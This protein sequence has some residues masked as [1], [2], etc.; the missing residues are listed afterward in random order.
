[1]STPE[2]YVATLADYTRNHVN[3][4]WLELHPDEPLDAQVAELRARSYC[5]DPEELII[6][7]TENFQGIDI[8]ESMPLD[9]VAKVGER[10]RTHGA[11][12]AAFVRYA[13]GGSDDPY[14]YEPVRF[15]GEYDD[16]EAW[17]EDVTDGL[18]PL[19]GATVAAWG[20]SKRVPVSGD[21]RTNL[22]DIRHALQIDGEALALIAEVN[23]GYTFAEHNGKVFV[24]SN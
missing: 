22:R 6:L 7:D 16:L 12:Y 11:P 3:A 19:L 8:H 20:R 17:A 18:L 2:I 4:A 5:A 9:Q 1:M 23:W 24:F 10:L 13:L 21:D 14:A 15:I